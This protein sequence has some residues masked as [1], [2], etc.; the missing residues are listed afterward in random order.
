MDSITPKQ[1]KDMCELHK[2]TIDL[3]RG[4]KVKRL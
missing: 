4:I 2:I 3:M 1:K